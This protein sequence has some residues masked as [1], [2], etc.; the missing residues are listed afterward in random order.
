MARCWCLGRR[1][2]GEGASPRAVIPERIRAAYDAGFGC[3]LRREG[4]QWVDMVELIQSAGR[5]GHC[6]NARGWDWM[7]GLAMR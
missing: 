5:A 7:S 1:G 4:A 3:R 6:G 2:C